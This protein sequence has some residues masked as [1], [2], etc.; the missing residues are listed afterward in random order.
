MLRINIFFLKKIFFYFLIFFSFSKNILSCNLNS[1]PKIFVFF[2][3]SKKLENFLVNIIYHANK[4][5]L[6]AAYNFTNK[7]ILNAIIDSYFKGVRVKILLDGK[8]N[9]KK[10]KLLNLLLKLGIPF[11]LNYSYKIMHNK[12]LIIDNNSVETGSYNYTF[13]ASKLNSENI[14]YLKCVPKIAVKYKNEF[15]N[16]WRKSNFM[17]KKKNLKK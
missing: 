9:C 17:I 6:I 8:N 3:P 14:I 7:N 12:F 4:E 11:R 2:S 5:I 15:F 13:S 16:L 10:K 1:K